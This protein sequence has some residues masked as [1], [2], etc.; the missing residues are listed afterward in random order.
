MN[1][2][3]KQQVFSFRDSFSIFDESGTEVYRVK[4][5]IISLGKKLHIYNTAGEEVAFIEQKIFA[6]L[7]KFHIYVKNKG[8]VEVVKHFTFWHQRYSVEP[9]GWQVE[10]DF[11]NHAYGINDKN[12]MVANISKQ[13]F[14]W[15]DTYEISVSPAADPLAAL[16]VVLCIDACLES[17]NN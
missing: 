8:Y 9:I 5:E 10:G 12:G 4:G 13:W 17:N 2:Y 6:F 11:T 3:I 1:F 7:P 15:G 14:T 16:G